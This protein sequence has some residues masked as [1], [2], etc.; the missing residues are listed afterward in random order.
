MSGDTN[1]GLSVS[2]D[3]VDVGRI[4]YAC[5]LRLRPRARTTTAISKVRTATPMMTKIMTIRG[6]PPTLSSSSPPPPLPAVETVVGIEGATLA[7]HCGQKSI[8]KR[9]VEHERSASRNRVSP[10]I[11]VMCKRV[12][13]WVSVDNNFM[14]GS[15]NNNQK[16]ATI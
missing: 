3:R 15:R 16:R 14:I 10:V 13:A 2:A 9:S 4:S 8:P 7:S 6:T 5:D 12:I 1:R 11:T